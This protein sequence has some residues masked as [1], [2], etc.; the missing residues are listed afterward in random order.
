MSKRTAPGFYFYPG[1][2]LRDTQNL[3]EKSQVAYDRIMCEHMRNVCI[4]K[5]QLNFFTKRLTEEEKKELE[6]VLTETSEGFQITWVAESVSK[7]KA[8]SDSRKKN[9]ESKQKE[10][11]SDI[12][13][14]HVEHM[15]IGI[16]EGIE[17]DKGSSLGKSENPLQ[18]PRT[19]KAFVPPSEEDMI[20]YAVEN[21][22]PPELGSRVHRYYSNMVPPW[23][24][25]EKR[26]VASWKSKMQSVWFKPENKLKVVGKPETDAERLAREYREKYETKQSA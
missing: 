3:S 13:A 22:Y 1:D 6:M 14:T 2:Y 16:G 7:S 17:V 25:A 23:H 8:Y 26:A 15:E 12:C 5:Q 11:V 21:G 10:D 9:R 19:K 20:G 18:K 4:S 24:D